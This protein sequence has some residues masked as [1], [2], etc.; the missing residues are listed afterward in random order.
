MEEKWD[1]YV[2]AGCLFC[3]RSWTGGPVYAAQ[4][5]W[6]TGEWTIT[7][8]SRAAGIEEDQ[9]RS[10]QVVDYLIKSHL[11]NLAAPHPLQPALKGDNQ[12]L[13]IASFSEFG[14]RAL[15]GTFD[16]LVHTESLERGLW[17]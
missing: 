12:A 9:S 4:L 16:D 11:Y 5:T 3:L 14:C 8:V 13:A 10:I 2:R 15:Y 17:G 7:E 6:L 1:L